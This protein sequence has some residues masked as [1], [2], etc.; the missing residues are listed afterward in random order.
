VDIGEIFQLLISLSCNSNKIINMKYFIVLIMW[1][2]WIVSTV[3]ISITIIGLPITLQE[4]WM[5]FGH[6]LIEKLK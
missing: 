4:E 5:D 2:L 1:I 3:A 6:E